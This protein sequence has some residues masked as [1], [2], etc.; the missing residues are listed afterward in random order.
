MA[1]EKDR[2]LSA[3]GTQVNYDPN[4]LE[5]MAGGRGSVD[6]GGEQ[7]NNNGQ[8]NNAGQ[9]N[10]EEQKQN[11][12]VKALNCIFTFFCYLCGLFFTDQNKM[13]K[14]AKGCVAI[15]PIVFL[16]WLVVCLIH[17]LIAF[18]LKYCRIFNSHCSF[19]KSENCTLPY[20][21]WKVTTAVTLSAV[22]ASVSYV[23][24]TLFILIPATRCQK[25]C[26]LDK[27]K[28]C[29]QVCCYTLRKLFDN[30]GTFLSPFEGKDSK[31]QPTGAQTVCFYLNYMFSL[32]VLVIYTVV[33]L[34]YAILVLSRFSC[35]INILNFFWYIFHA[36]FHLCAIH[37]CFIF[38]KVIYIATNKLEQ[39]S[40]DLCKF[41]VDVAALVEK[42]AKAADVFLKKCITEDIENWFKSEDK[43]KVKSEDK[44]KL[45]SEDLKKWLKSNS[46]DIKEKGQ[47]YLFQSTY[48]SVVE[49]VKPT[50]NLLGYWFI[51]HWLLHALT[52]VL[53]SSVIIELVVNLLQYKATKADEMIDIDDGG[54]KFLYVTYLVFFALE[55]A[56]LFFYPC[57]RASSIASTH[58]KLVKEVLNKQWEYVSLS[59][60]TK[61]VQ[62]LTSQNFAFKVSVFCV[63]LTF[64]L[65]MACVSLILALYGGLIKLND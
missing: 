39:I 11:C 3:C 42:D 61:F 36:G 6:H 27:K 10:N 16:A 17:V 8:G 34:V 15:Q 52:T 44:K 28:V 51:A 1:T 55:H 9:G 29:H 54:L 38:S 49:K 37:S 32:L 26:K 24:M 23:L 18:G 59:V 14:I 63:E 25:S 50:L 48:R 33:S 64:G 56:F 46:K 47:Y 20:E 40:N 35:A 21:Y 13:S 31:D 22:A 41:D 53:L 12:P 57:F 58:M 2:L 60:I 7:G 4:A 19:M 62:Y 45:K 5:S 30:D 43:K 65:S